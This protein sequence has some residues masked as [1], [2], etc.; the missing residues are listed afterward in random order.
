MVGKYINKTNTPNE[1]ACKR[2]CAARGGGCA[3]GRS[4]KRRITRRGAKAGFGT[5]AKGDMRGMTPKEAKGDAKSGMRRPKKR[6]RIKR[7]GRPRPTAA[8]SARSAGRIRE[9]EDRVKEVR[10]IL[11]MSQWVQLEDVYDDL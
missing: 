3:R 10:I 8:T 7:W 6:S 9:Y 4:D 2:A 11:D 1:R 5:F